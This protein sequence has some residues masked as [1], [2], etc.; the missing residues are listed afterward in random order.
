MRSKLAIIGS[1]GVPAKYGGF[2]TLAEFL[3][4]HLGKAMQTTIYCSGKTYKS[5][6][7]KQFN[8]CKLVYIALDA[9][10]VQ[11]IPYD[12]LSL[13]H[14][15]FTTNIL[16]V[17]GVAG[18]FMF[19]F[20][21]LFS[22]KRVVVNIDGIEHRREKWSPLAKK[23][24]KWAESLAVK[25]SHAVVADNKGIQE[26]VKETY[27]KDSVVI[28]YGG[29]HVNL[30]PLSTEIKLKYKL[31]EEY[32]FKVCRIEPE[33]NIHII[34][35]AFSKVEIPLVM[36]GNWLY[37]AY[38]RDL[39]KQYSKFPHIYLIDPI[40]EQQVLN[41]IRSNCSLYVHGHSAGGTNPSLVEAMFLGK[42]IIAFDVNYN[43]Y[44]TNEQALFFKNSKE[45]SVLLKAML[46][47]SEA[48]EKAVK[49]QI[50][51]QQNYKWELIAKA[52]QKALVVNGK[53][54]LLTIN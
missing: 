28:P 18:S 29:D 36:V 30:E 3:S 40:Y 12:V 38:G 34:L 49:A 16:L 11:S 33:N 37:S 47:P 54:K 25:Y 39:H 20:I 24:L 46:E 44:T 17:L 4:L 8:N 22:R 14:A 19:P 51:A 42:P 9:N 45:L 13:V 35:E 26:Y 21:R 5:E 27:N 15:F 23:Y 10:G 7:R 48:Y 31:P 1:V 52:Y 53:K 41:Q 6:K 50:Y 43:R 32:A 2:E